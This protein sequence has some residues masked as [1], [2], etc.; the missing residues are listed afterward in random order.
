MSSLEYDKLN[1]TLLG[2]DVKTLKLKSLSA[3]S[4]EK[5]EKKLKLEKPRLKFFIC[6]TSK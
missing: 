4:K 3:N 1:Q 6:F 2:L 5:M